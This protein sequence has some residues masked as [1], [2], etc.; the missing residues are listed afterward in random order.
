MRKVSVMIS[1]LLLTILSFFV[2]RLD[3]TNSGNGQ[4]NLDMGQLDKNNVGE[5]NRQQSILDN[6]G[7]PIF[8]EE[9]MN[10]YAD[11]V[12]RQDMR[13]QQFIDGLFL[14][15]MEPDAISL[16]EALFVEAPAVALQ[17]AV[18]EE[19]RYFDISYMIYFLVTMVGVL[20]VVFL[21]MIVR[22]DLQTEQI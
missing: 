20:L 11:G 3:A 19:E 16:S 14:Q 17:K 10:Q 1:I 21:I 15:E 5:T 8:T 12:A 6:Y 4:L 7:I 22:K 9:A 18:I 2:V 13:H